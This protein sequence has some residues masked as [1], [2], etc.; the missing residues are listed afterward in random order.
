MIKLLNPIST[1]FKELNKFIFIFSCILCSLLIWINYNF[2]IDTIINSKN[3]VLTSFLFRYFVFLLAFSLP[4]FFTS[5]TL[6]KNYFK[7]KTF[8]LLLALAPAIFS[9]KMC[10]DTDIDISKQLHLNEYWNQVLYWPLR[11]ILIVAFLFCIQKFVSFQNTFWGFTLKNF[12]WKPYLVLITFMVPLIT[13][14]SSQQDFLLVYPKAQSIQL[15]SL[16]SE[17]NWL[18]VLLYEASYGSDFISI[19][20][21]FRGFLIFA[22]IKY[23]GKE[24][25]LP[26]ACFYCTIHFGKPLAECISSFFGG[27]ILGIIAFHT[28]SIIG[29]LLV[30]LG[31]AWLM[32]IG[33]FLG[34]KFL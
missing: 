3:S 32:E 15:S 19:E 25:I 27:M 26:M 22:F 2:N 21:F 9:L 12:S 31:I 16:Q 34:N 29:G 24:A 30:H 4:Y 18:Y 13:I 1:Y 10:L 11:L 33:G 28:R 8:I 23:A 14:A 5:I 20:L 7:S 17:Y 6:H